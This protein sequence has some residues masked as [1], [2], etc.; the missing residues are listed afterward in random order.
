MRDSGRVNTR[1]AFGKR[2]E[3][4]LGS[5]LLSRSGLGSMSP[6]DENPHA[7]KKKFNFRCL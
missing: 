4:R 7:V 3:F 2:E 5:A 6:M 1:F